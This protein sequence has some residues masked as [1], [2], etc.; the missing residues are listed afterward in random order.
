MAIKLFGKNNI[1]DDIMEILFISVFNN[2]VV[3]LAIN[4]LTS[5]K[6]VGINNYCAFCLDMEC[7][8]KIKSLGFTCEFIKGGEYK[9]F[10]EFGSKEF[11]KLSFMRYPIISKILSQN[12]IVWYMDVDTVVLRNMN[13]YRFH[14]NIDALFQ[15]DLNML[16]TG[17]MCFHPTEKS[18]TLLNLVWSCRNYPNNDQIVLNKILHSFVICIHKLKRTDFPNGKVYKERNVFLNP[19]LVHANYMTGKETK[20]TQLKKWKLWFI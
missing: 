10:K 15:D 7:Y 19:T 6:K 1:I 16:C 13:L 4:H 14:R 12:K 18:K 8:N 9:E 11:N 20:I 17:C 3:E 2:G 5:L